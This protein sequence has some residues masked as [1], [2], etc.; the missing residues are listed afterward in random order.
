MRVFDFV[1]AEYQ[2]KYGEQDWVHIRNG[3]TPEFHGY[4]VHFL[5]TELEAH[6]LDGFAIKG[7]KEQALFEFPPGGSCLDEVFDVIAELCG[8]DRSRMVL[9]ER[10]IQAYEANAAAEPIAH[11]DRYPGGWRRRRRRRPCAAR[12]AGATSSAGSARRATGVARTVMAASPSTTTRAGAATSCSWA[13]IIDQ[14]SP[15][16]RPSRWVW[17]RRRGLVDDGRPAAGGGRARPGRCLLY[18]S[19]AADEEDSV[20]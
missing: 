2:E 7:K 18:T 20:D 4:L 6:L 10:H 9:S 13:P 16:V 17:A 1:P 5:E 15:T 12:G 3:I 19:D 8:L 14:S 11:K